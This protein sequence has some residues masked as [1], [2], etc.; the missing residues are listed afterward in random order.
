MLVSFRGWI[1]F[2]FIHGNVWKKFS[3]LHPLSFPTVYFI[4]LSFPLP[5]FINS[6]P[7]YFTTFYQKRQTKI[8]ATSISNVFVPCAS[9]FFFVYIRSF[10]NREPPQE[11]ERHKHHKCRLGTYL[12]ASANEANSFIFCGK[13]LFRSSRYIYINNF[14]GLQWIPLRKVWQPSSKQQ[15]WRIIG[16]HFY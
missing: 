8:N 15:L 13:C 2:W 3:L 4:S 10:Y 5:L 1:L 9:H 16:F 6:V 14:R 7:I 11:R 12:L